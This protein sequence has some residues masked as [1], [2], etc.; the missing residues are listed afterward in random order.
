MQK[1]ITIAACVLVLA[2][3]QTGTVKIAQ[4]DEKLKRG[5]TQGYETLTPIEVKFPNNNEQF[6][7]N[8]DFSEPPSGVILLSD[9]EKSFARL[10]RLPNWT[11]VYSIKLSSLMSGSLGDPALFY[12][13]ATML[14]ANFKPTR[15]TTQ[16]D[17][18]FRAIG[19]RGLISADFWVNEADKREAFM[20]VSG[21]PRAQLIVPIGPVLVMWQVPVGGTE[22]PKVMRA[23]NAGQVIAIFKPLVSKQF[24][25]Q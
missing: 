17:F 24:G 18:T 15:N 16:K 20:L 23:A 3:Y 9:G 21:E 11:G 13:R 1:L 14:D 25:P 8:V 19:E 7:N 2:G 10:Y 4:F 12:P 6:V 5:L 22:L